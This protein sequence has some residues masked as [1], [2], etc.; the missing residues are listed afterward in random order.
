M[1]FLKSLALGFLLLPLT[2]ATLYHLPSIALSLKGHLDSIALVFAGLTGYVLIEA[3]FERPMRTYVFGHELTHALASI[4]MG[5]KVHDFKVSEKGGSVSL[6]KSNFIVALAPYCVPIY[7]LFALLAYWVLKY[8]YPFP[9]MDAVFLILVGAT[10]AFHV[11]LT[12]YAVRQ[13]QPDIKKTGTVFSLV[14]IVLMNSWLLAAL[15]KILFWNSFGAW[16]FVTDVVKTQSDIW[17]SIWDVSA[18][19]VKFLHE[20]VLSRPSRLS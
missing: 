20:T 19:F 13:E 7:T 3:L 16:D 2:L 5:G 6:S 14:F 17:K 1:K 4:A 12:L 9:N 10:L 15:S 11:S 18:N 8:V